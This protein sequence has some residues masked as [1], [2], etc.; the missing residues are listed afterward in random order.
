MEAMRTAFSV[1]SALCFTALFATVARGQRAALA[2]SV[3]A[4]SS[5]RPIA[6]AEVAIPL[7]KLSTHA[8]DSGAFRL[9]GITPGT[10]MIIVRQLG[11]APIWARLTFADTQTVET[12]FVLIRRVVT[13]D[14]VTATEQLPAAKMRGFE[15]RRALGIGHFLTR[16]DLAKKENWRMAELLSQVPGV[17]IVR[18]RAGQAF[19]MNS[20]GQS[21]IL[22]NRPGNRQLGIPPGCYADVYLDGVE[23][24]AGRDSMSHF[25]VNSIVPFLLEGVEYYS[26]PAEA[27]IQYSGTGKTCGVLSLWTRISK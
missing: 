8:N 23:V 6:G 14:T 20:R 18:G 3:I 19:V 15:E 22:L 16:D 1:H 5:E 26:G 24:Y 13:L 17:R 21:T 25:D 9:A 27:P 4:D 7:L 11:Y 2:G 10:H 12:D